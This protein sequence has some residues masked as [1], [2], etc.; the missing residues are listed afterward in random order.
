MIDQQRLESHLNNGEKEYILCAA[1]YVN[2]GKE[3]KFKPFNID[4]GIVYCGWR[5]HQIFEQIFTIPGDTFTEVQGFLTN[6]NRFLDRK[7]AL[8]LVKTNGQ[9]TKSIIGGTLTSE[10]LW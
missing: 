2:N 7:E 9:L 5:H 10:D 6:K 1:I 3:Y 8:E 4:K